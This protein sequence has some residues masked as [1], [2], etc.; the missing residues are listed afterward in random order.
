MVSRLCA[1]RVAFGIGL[2]VLRVTL[3]GFEPPFVS[4]RF[5]LF[6]SSPFLCMGMCANDALM[7]LVQV[8]H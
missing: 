3:A 6:L 1:S 4:R 8:V 7:P 5:S 2:E